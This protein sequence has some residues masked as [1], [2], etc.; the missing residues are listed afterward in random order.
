MGRQLFELCGTD[1]LR[2]LRPFCWRSSMALAHKNLDLASLPWRFTGTDRLAFAGHEKVP[3]LVDGERVVADFWAIMQRLDVAYPDA[4]SLVRGNPAPYRFVASWN[5]HVVQAGIARLVASDTPPLLDETERAYLV[6]SRENRFGKKL[7]EVTG[8]REARLPTFRQSLQPLR[9]LLADQ[10][11]TGR[12]SPD[13]ADFII[14][15]SFMWPLGVS[16]LKLLAAVAPILA[17]RERLLGCH[18]AHARNAPCFG[19]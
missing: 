15:G 4:P 19:A 11:S 16:P 2:V 18:P 14:F 17:W 10:A 3:V 1:P 9:A 6:E 5:D 8:A 12:D 13:Y 7:E